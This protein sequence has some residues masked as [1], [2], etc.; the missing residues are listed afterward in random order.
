MA[1]D[2]DLSLNTAKLSGVCGRLM[3]C[4]AYEQQQYVEVKSKCPEIGSKVFTPAG[5]GNLISIDCIRETGTVEYSEN[6]TKSFSLSQIKKVF[7]KD[8]NLHKGKK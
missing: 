7:E 8:K 5:K 1:K 3:C 2:Q 6:D 4:L